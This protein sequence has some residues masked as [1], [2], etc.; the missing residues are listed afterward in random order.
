MLSDRALVEVFVSALRV[1]LR[2]NHLGRG[3]ISLAEEKEITI[4]GRGFYQA[5]VDWELS[6]VEGVRVTA[7]Q[8]TYILR[9]KK[10]DYFIS[11]VAVLGYY[12]QDRLVLDEVAGS[13][14]V[15]E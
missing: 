14:S 10:F 11:M 4:G 7:R 15:L 8:V 9:S 12:E 1:T 5:V 6:P 13:F 3:T 2:D